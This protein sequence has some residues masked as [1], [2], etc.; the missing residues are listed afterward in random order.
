MPSPNTRAVAA[1]EA[2]AAL[3]F[4][5]RDEARTLKE[6]E[7]AG[8]DRPQCSIPAGP[9]QLSKAHDGDL[10]MSEFNTT[11]LKYVKSRMGFPVSTPIKMRCVFANSPVF[12]VFDVVSY[13]SFQTFCTRKGAGALEQEGVVHVGVVMDSSQKEKRKSA[14]QMLGVR[15]GNAKVRPQ[16]RNYNLLRRILYAEADIELDGVGASEEDP[17]DAVVTSVPSHRGKTGKWTAKCD[18][19]VAGAEKGHV[20]ITC[21][22]DRS[23][24][25]KL[26]VGTSLESKGEQL[27][28]NPVVGLC[29]FKYLDDD[30][31][32]E[33]NSKRHVLGASNSLRKLISKKQG[34]LLIQH[35]VDS[36]EHL[37][38]LAPHICLNLSIA[39]VCPAPDLCLA[40]S[41]EW[42]MCSRTAP[43]QDAA[44]HRL[45]ARLTM[46]LDN[47]QMNEA[48]I[49]ASAGAHIEAPLR[50]GLFDELPDL[51]MPP[52]KLQYGDHADATAR[53]DWMNGT[54]R[55]AATRAEAAAA[56]ATAAVAAVQAQEVN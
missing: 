13:K 20:L 37:E 14:K 39:V 40:S 43:M 54:V 15:A 1:G 19:I 22:R 21:L 55:L 27:L 30:Q 50:D 10:V 6:L 33:C 44:A 4:C 26:F 12:E 29:P 7:E 2:Y 42:P 16:V 28:L 35:K 53:R 46:A 47:R 49:T 38:P 34:H 9:A 52:F 17:E 18:E 48:S 45:A 11:M 3:Q 32:R 56:A 51:F 36:K 24:L 8:I 5:M 41:H 31:H 23:I 25:A